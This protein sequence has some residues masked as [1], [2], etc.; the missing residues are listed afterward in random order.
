MARVTAHTVLVGMTVREAGCREDLQ[1]LADRTGASLA[2]LQIGEPSLGRELDRVAAEGAEQITLVGVSLG[3]S[4][5][6][7]WLRRV[8]AHWWRQGQN[9]PTVDVAA[10]VVRSLD[11]GEV[12]LAVASERTRVTGAEAG[13]T[14]PPWE[15]VP[16]HRFHVLVCRGPRC[17]AQ[18]SDETAAAMDASLGRAGLSDDDVLVTQTGCLF[19]CNQAPVVVIHP[20]DEWFGRVDGDVAGRLV[21]ERIIGGARM[22]GHLLPRGK[23]QGI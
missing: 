4:P 17:T 2:F 10:E 21:A 11:V 14:S 9:R 6:R 7:S 1:R 16:G 18:G 3:T 23:H 19:P 20:D 8:A 12:E 5:A 15:N 22:S 13:L